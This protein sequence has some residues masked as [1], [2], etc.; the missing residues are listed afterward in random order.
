MKLVRLRIIKSI[1]L[2]SLVY[3][4]FVT[5]TNT[6][7]NMQT[8]SKAKTES[9]TSTLATTMVK[10][11][12]Q[13]KTQSSAKAMTSIFSYDFLSIMK[14]KMELMKEKASLGNKSGK[15]SST[16]ATYTTKFPK[17]G[18]EEEPGQAPTPAATP[19]P[20]S[21][22]PEPQEE[23][24]GQIKI[25]DGPIFFAGWVKYFKFS[26]SEAQ[27]KPNAF[28]K[29]N[30]F[31][32]QLKLHPQADTS[33]KGSDGQYIYV[34][35]ESHFYA[36]LFKDSLTITSN[37]YNNTA[38]VFDN[39]YLDKIQPVVEGS[40]YS[41]GIIDFGAFSE[42]SCFKLALVTHKTWIICTDNNDDKSKLMISIKNIKLLH[43]REKGE[44]LIS[45]PEKK[46]E[47]LENIMG[48]KKEETDKGTDKNP[49]DGHWMLLQDW[50]QCSKKCD[51]GV[52]TLHRLCIPPQHGGKPCE[53]EAILT[54]ECNPEPCP[55]FPGEGS[56]NSTKLQKLAKPV[57]LKPIV[58]VMPYSNKPQ[59]YHKCII[60]E[61]DL[62]MTRDFEQNNE[63]N[64][65]SARK[66]KI[67]SV[68]VPVRAVLNNRTLTFYENAED[69]SSHFITFNLRSADFSHSKKRGCFI[70][71]DGHKRAELCP[72]MCDGKDNTYN[73]WD[74][75][76]HT[77]KFNCKTPAD[78]VD[79]DLEGKLAEKMKDAKS[80]LLLEREEEVKK[81]VQ[82]K[83]E[84]NSNNIIKETSQVA[85]QA[86]MKEENL[87]ELI[88][89]EEQEKEV[90]E[91]KTIEQEIESEK[92]KNV[93][94]TLYFLYVLLGLCHARYKRT[95]IG[96]PIPTKKQGTR[97]GS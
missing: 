24:M 78:T 51:K 72:F 20:A 96:E 88:E 18:A 17:P 47:S 42:G 82:E 80:N 55:S 29:N 37:R 58:K 1:L 39:L 64:N 28:F 71:S 3:I 14:K 68:Q 85:Q 84:Q 33:K 52:S 69:F 11:N 30:Y 75:A 34:P 93:R 2:I 63:D 36:T 53:G 22:E 23:P 65:E 48:D 92:K 6:Q 43:Q 81:K 94:Y 79:F 74:E 7:T 87:E 50:S 38:R 45:E 57:T 91:E 32:E 90:Q 54:R 13:M 8:N 70:I 41:G 59:R 26:E 16:K 83:D 56:N 19:T 9:K 25:G 31:F 89:K 15:S 66:K 77:F 49:K 4:S 97:K 27:E 44:I 60:K 76:F 86:I 46:E 10:T 21:P 62:M 40:G 67:H 95:R 5:S 73:E 35:D 12:S 61:S